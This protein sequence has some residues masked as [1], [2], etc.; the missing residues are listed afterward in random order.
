MITN[1]GS[2]PIL[3]GIP[4]RPGMSPLAE[5]KIIPLTMDEIRAG[6]P[7]VIEQWRDTFGSCWCIAGKIAVRP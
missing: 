7:V 1:D 4:P 5:Q 3:Q 2:E 6:V